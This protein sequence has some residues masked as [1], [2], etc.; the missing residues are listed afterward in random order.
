[1]SVVEYII[2]KEENHKKT[3]ICQNYLKVQSAKEQQIIEMIYYNQINI[4]S[5]MFF[6]T[7]MF[8]GYN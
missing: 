3:S 1:M 4:D 2:E 6:D 5:L 8:P 7:R